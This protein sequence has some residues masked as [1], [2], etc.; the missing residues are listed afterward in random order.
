M[1]R[2]SWLLSGTMALALGCGGDTASTGKST[3][4][5]ST[6]T[7]DGAKVETTTTKSEVKRPKEGVQLPPVDVPEPAPPKA[8][9]DKDKKTP[10]PDEP[11][12][13]KPVDKKDK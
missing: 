12:T 1:N 13:P 3:T 2:T 9:T 5:K 6:T 8:I 7:S 4:T 11:K 10:T